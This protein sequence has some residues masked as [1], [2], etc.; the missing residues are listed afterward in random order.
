M[1]EG[2]SWDPHKGY[3]RAIHNFARIDLE[4]YFPRNR[5]SWTNPNQPLAIFDIYPDG[6][7]YYT[8]HNPSD[9][10]DTYYCT[11]T[12]SY[13][14]NNAEKYDV[15]SY[16]YDPVIPHNEE[17]IEQTVQTYDWREIIYQMAKDYRQNGHEDDFNVRLKENNGLE[18][19]TGYT[20]YE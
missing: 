19:P 3:Y 1:F 13:F 16:I 7:L 2:E 9:P 5:A 18:Y 20:G 11:H 12:L 8:G 4:K 10:N 6:S 17:L 15:L 14:I